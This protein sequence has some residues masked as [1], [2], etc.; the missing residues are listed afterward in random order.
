MTRPITKTLEIRVP[1]S[2]GWNTSDLIQHIKRE[3]EA[4]R[5]AGDK[6]NVIQ[7]D[8]IE[9]CKLY[10]NV[11]SQKYNVTIILANVEVVFNI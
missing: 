2:L 10:P 5:M 1:N 3:F 4:Q 9:K 11:N 8:N 7:I 6:Y